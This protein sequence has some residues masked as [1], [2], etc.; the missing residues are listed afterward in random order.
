MESRL[1]TDS[2]FSFLEKLFTDE[3]TDKRLSSE[4]TI[5]RIKTIP[6]F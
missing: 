1:Q 2:I 3:D 4:I 5:S 6:V